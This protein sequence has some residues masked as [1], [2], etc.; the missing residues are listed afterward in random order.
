MLQ[1]GDDEIVRRLYPSLRR[2]AA[3][4]GCGATEPDDLVQDALV[5]TLRVHGLADLD[6]PEAYLR[7]S[8]VNLARNGRR[9][10]WRRDDLVRRLGAPAAVTAEFPS[11]IADLERLAPAERAVVYLKVVE[12]RPYAEIAAELGITEEAARARS[13]RATAKLRVLI[14]EE[15]RRG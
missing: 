10:R 5:A 2:F 13:S 9:N 11:D 3:V 15:M 6:F 1:P 14:V 12:G 4:V 7:R 8:I